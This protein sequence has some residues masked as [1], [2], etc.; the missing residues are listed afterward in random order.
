VAD[1]RYCGSSD[2]GRRG[3]A[4]TALAALETNLRRQNGEA[5]PFTGGRWRA[6]KF[7]DEIKRKPCSGARGT[8]KGARRQRDTWRDSADCHSG[9]RLSIL[10]HT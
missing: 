4:V 5:E 6:V 1:G 7:R 9:N 3:A 8:A 10:K 2:E